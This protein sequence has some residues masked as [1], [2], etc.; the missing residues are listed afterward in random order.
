ME[1][2][3]LEIQLLPGTNVKKLNILECRKLD[4]IFIYFFLLEDSRKEHRQ[5]HIHV[6][7]NNSKSPSKANTIE[8][9]TRMKSVS[10]CK[11]CEI[12]IVWRLDPIH[13]E[14]DPLYR[15]RQKKR[16]LVLSLVL[17]F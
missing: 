14:Y 10:K 16:G 12:A 11:S 2:Q 9:G 7:N 5:T 4:N 13:T 6:Q 15:K 1:I 8:T 3:L 17:L